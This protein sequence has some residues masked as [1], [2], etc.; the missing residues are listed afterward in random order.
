MR[1]LIFALLTLAARAAAPPA[2]VAQWT[3]YEV[4]LS[5]AHAY[6]NAVQ[7]VEVRVTLTAPSG[8]TDEVLAFWDGGRRWLFRY[9]PG[10]LGEWHWK[11]IARAPSAASPTRVPMRSTATAR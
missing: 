9:A 2:E 5:S 11:T 3:R 8:R 7:D 1:M 10:E 6:D 4:E